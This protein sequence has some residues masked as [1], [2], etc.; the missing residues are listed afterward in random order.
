ML[1]WIFQIQIKG[2]NFI[3]SFLCKLWLKMSYF[4]INISTILFYFLEWRIISSS[5][6]TDFQLGFRFLA[7]WISKSNNFCSLFSS[8]DFKKI[9]NP[10]S[11]IL[12]KI[13]IFS[14]IGLFTLDWY[15][16][17]TDE[18]SKWKD[19]VPLFKETNLLLTPRCS[20][21]HWRFWKYLN[22]FDFP[23]LFYFC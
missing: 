21:I 12:F 3:L 22:I 11:V 13:E 4:H 15:E 1:E 17:L 8:K 7:E 10:L 9:S 14:E 20:C 19:S 16:A 2:I 18:K 6:C 23:D 5:I